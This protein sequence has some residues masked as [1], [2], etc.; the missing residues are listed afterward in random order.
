MEVPA[1]LLEPEN[2]RDRPLVSVVPEVA[3]VLNV[4]AEGPHVVFEV[5][6]DFGVVGH[7]PHGGVAGD[8]MID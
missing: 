8:E 5:A 2:P 4:A 3:T 7:W 6:A 1:I